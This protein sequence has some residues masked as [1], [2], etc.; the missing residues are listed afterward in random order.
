MKQSAEFVQRYLNCEYNT[1]IYA[2]IQQKSDLF[3]AFPAFRTD[4][5]Q[6]IRVAS[7][8]AIQIQFWC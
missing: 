7:E 3:E 5:N 4:P 8:W 6:K 2:T 1:K